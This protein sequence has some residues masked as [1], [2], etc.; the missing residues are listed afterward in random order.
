[1]FLRSAPC[2]DAWWTSYKDA[3]EQRGRRATVRRV[4]PTHQRP[5]LAQRRRKSVARAVRRVRRLRSHADQFVLLEERQTLLQGRLR[6]VILN[7]M[8]IQ[9]TKSRAFHQ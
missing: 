1:V 9:R 5:L 8:H 7:I 3:A 6:Q 4:R 2:R